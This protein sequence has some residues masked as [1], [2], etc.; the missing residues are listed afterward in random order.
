MTLINSK[1]ALLWG[2]EVKN[3][4]YKVR[5]DGYLQDLI[6]TPLTI[7]PLYL[8]VKLEHALS[9]L[10]CLVTKGDVS[11]V[12]K[13][14][15]HNC[16]SCIWS[17]KRGCEVKVLDTQPLVTSKF[18]GREGKILICKRVEQMPSATDFSD[19]NSTPVSFL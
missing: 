14:I 13:H 11:F 1:C 15:R 10:W 19:T 16:Q 5:G 4:A 17:A 9:H 12:L 18:Q 7:P 3:G 6:E 2:S 8:N